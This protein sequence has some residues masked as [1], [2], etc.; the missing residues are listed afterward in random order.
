MS[1]VTNDALDISDEVVVLQRRVAQL[2]E[3]LTVMA[4]VPLRSQTGVQLA[5]VF[6]REHLAGIVGSDA[7]VTHLSEAA[8]QSYPTSWTRMMMDIYMAMSACR[9]S[10]AGVEVAELSQW[11]GVP[12][13]E[14][15]DSVR[16]LAEARM[17]E[18]VAGHA[19]WRCT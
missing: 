19:A 16:A 6:R 10:R 18:S 13:A 2:F 11:L 4:Q 1:W 15:Y 14:V 9:R 3:A 12:R 5:D 8:F 17:I 7:D